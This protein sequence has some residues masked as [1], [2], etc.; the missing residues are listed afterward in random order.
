M[1]QSHT[2]QLDKW[3]DTEHVPSTAESPLAEIIIGCGCDGQPAAAMR[4]LLAADAQN[5]A[6]RTYPESI[7]VSFGGFHTSLPF[8]PMSNLTDE[9]LKIWHEMRSHC[10]MGIGTYQDVQNLRT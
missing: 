4:R 7:F 3:K 2:N 6:D 9:N 10:T 1:V 5:G 8:S